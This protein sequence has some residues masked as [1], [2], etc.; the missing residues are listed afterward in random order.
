MTN[1]FKLTSWEAEEHNEQ[2]MTQM[3]FTGEVSQW[4]LG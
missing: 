4:S 1:T 3:H 2:R